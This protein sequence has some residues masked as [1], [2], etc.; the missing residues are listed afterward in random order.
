MSI[1]FEDKNL[2]EFGELDPEIFEE[3]V[4]ETPEP[5]PEPEPEVKPKS[6][7]KAGT[8]T[9]KAVAVNT[10]VFQGPTV[11]SHG[12]FR[13]RRGNLMTV[14]SEEDGWLEVEVPRVGGLEVGYIQADKVVKV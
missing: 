12:L 4:E 3:V 2:D 7:K 9:V 11:F 13:V 10:W 1:K 6:K 14:L 5:E 8:K